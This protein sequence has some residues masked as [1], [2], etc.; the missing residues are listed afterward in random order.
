MS[1]FAALIET[2]EE[3]AARL[4]AAPPGSDEHRM[5]ALPV[6]VPGHPAGLVLELPSEGDGQ[7]IVVPINEQLDGRVRS[8]GKLLHTG[9]FDCIVVHSTFSGYRTGR[10]ISVPHSQIRRARVVSLEGA[11]R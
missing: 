8:Q 4:A 2:D 9:A 11:L 10:I 7:I 5:A 3:E 6:T 1:I